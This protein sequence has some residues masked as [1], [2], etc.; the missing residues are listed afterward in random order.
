MDRK[1]E[2]K[3]ALKGR[4]FVVRYAD[5]FVIGFTREDNARRVWDVLREGDSASTV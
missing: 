4:A 5:D 1:R 3:R 2:V